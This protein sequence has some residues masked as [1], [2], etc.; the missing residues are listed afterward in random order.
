MVDGDRSITY[1]ELDTRSSR[2]ARLLIDDGA[3]PESIVAVA[4]T[5][6]VESI[7]AIWAVIKAGAA[8]LPVDP[9]Y[10]VERIRHLLTDSGAALGVTTAAYREALPS[11]CSWFVLD[12]DAFVSRVEQYSSEPVSTSDRTA[13]LRASNPAYVIYTSGSTGLPKGVVVSQAGLAD[14]CA[15]SVRALGV[16]ASSRTLHFTSPSFDVSIFDYL[17][18]IGSSATMVIVPLDNYGGDE[19][20][21]LL[22]RERVTHG[23]STPAALTSIDGEGLPDL[24][25]LV[26]GGEAFGADL[27]ARWAPG[28]SLLNGYGPTEAT[29]FATMSTPLAVGERV[30]L[31]DPVEGMRAYVLDTRLS[32]VPPGVVGELYLAGGGVARGYHGRQALTSDR[33]VA[34]PRDTA[35]GRMYRTG[36]MVR[37]DASG[38]LEYLGRND[39]QV[40]IRGFRIEL[41]EIDAVLGARA[42]VEFALTMGI[43]TGAGGTALVSYA[44]PAKGCAVES[45]ELLDWMR[46]SLPKHMVPSALIVIDH[47][48][49]TGAGKVD[50][51]A[52]PAPVFESRDYREP[53]TPTE[54]AVAAVFAELLGQE[55][56]GA[57]DDFFE[58]GG[59]SLIGTQVAARVGARLHK[60]VPARLLFDAP[61]VSALAAAIDTQTDQGPRLDLVARERPARIPLSLAQQR[62]WFL[63]RFDPTS[64]A[65]NIPVAVHLSGVLDADALAAAVT[66]VVERHETLRTIYPSD[67]NGPHQVIL[68]AR[69]ASVGIDR[70]RTTERDV[71]SDVLTSLGAAFD[72]ETDVP[73]RISLFEL[74]DTE[75]VLVVVVHHIAADGSSVVPLTRDVMIAY[76]ARA[77]RETPQWAPLGVQY[78]DY[79]LW[80]REMLGDVED[81]TS[82]AYAQTEFWKSALAGL[83]DQLDLP[84]DR[85][86]PPVQSLAGGE[87]P[88]EL[89]AE[90]HQALTEIARVSNASLFM[91]M[92]A[93]WAVTLSRL[94]QRGDIAV[95]SPIAGRGEAQLDDLI[96]MFAN[97]IV[98]RT[99]VRWDETFAD[100]LRSVR[101]T[102]LEA[103]A[104]ADVPF[105]TLV[106]ALDTVRSTARHPLFQVGLSFQNIARTELVLPELT[107]T[108]VEADASVSKFDLHLIV[109]D[110]YSAQGD[111]SGLQVVLTYASAL[112]DRSTAAATLDRYVRVLRAIVADPRIAIGDI[113]LLDAPE[114]VVA[115]DTRNATAR[116]VDE[117]STLVSLFDAAVDK[118][119]DATAVVFRSER[120]TYARFD[121]R[122]NALARHLVSLRIGPESLVALA[123]PRSVELLVAMYA[124]VKAGAAYVPVDPAQP[125]SRTDHILQTADV[126]AV[127]TSSDVGFTT[128]ARVQ[129]VELDALD[130]GSYASSPITDSERVSTLRPSNTAYVIFTSGST[131]KPK[132]VAVSHAS[133]VNQLEW[134]RHEYRLGASDA[135]VL[136]TPVT[137][138]LSVWELWS[139]P[140]VGGRLVVAEP[141]RHREP[142]YLNEL[143][144]AEVVTT[145][146]V[147]PSM[148]ASLVSSGA[149]GLPASVERALVIGEAFPPRA[150][151]AVLRGH[152]LRVD[153]L[154]GPTEA[155]VSV[156]S[157]TVA[158]EVGE[159]D[160]IP[161]GLPEWNTQVYV[162]DARLAPV[163]DGVVGELY[164]AGVQLAR[165]YQGR[166]DLTAERFV[167]NPYS[168][169]ASRL[170]RTGD[171]VRWTTAGVLDYVGRADHQVKVRGFRIELGDIE[172]ALGS[173][174]GV[175][176]AVVVDHV[177]RHVGTTL[178]GYVV[179][180]VEPLIV[181]KALAQSLPSY[182]VPS[183]IVVLD[184]LPLTVNGKIDRSA[185]PAP[186]FETTTYRAPTTPVE[187]TVAAVVAE[188]LGAARVGADD[189]FFALGGNSLLATQVVARLGAALD[190]QV[191]VRAIFEDPTVAALA[192]RVEEHAGSGAAIPLVPVERPDVIPL[193]L[194]QRRMWFLN[195][196]DPQSATENIPVAVRLSG[197]LDL[198][199][200]AAAVR[201][202]IARHEVL[203]TMY[204][205]IDGVGTQVVLGAD[206]VDLDLVPRSVPEDALVPEVTAVVGAPFDV[207]SW[208]PLRTRVLRVAENEHV[209]VLVTHH[210][211]ADGFSMTPLARDVMI[212]YATRAEGNEPTWAPLPVQY[213]DYT[214]WQHRVLGEPDDP[215][216]TGAQ[217]EH[218]WRAELAGLPEQLELPT[219][220]PRPRAASGL[221]KSVTVD[222]GGELHARIAELARTHRAT[223]FMVVHAALAVLLSRMSGSA[224]VAVGTPMAGR[225][226]AA[227][228][229]LVGMFVNTLVLRTPIDGTASFEDVLADVARI[230]LAAFGH[231]DLPFE[232]VVEVVDP[233]RSQGRHPLVQV[234]LAFQNTERTTFELPGLTVSAVDIGTT[235][236]KMDLQVTVV[237]HW[238]GDGRPSGYGITFTYATD[239]F[240]DASVAELA[241]ALVRT[242]EAATH[243]PRG[244]VG[245]IDLLSAE[246]RRRMSTSWNDTAHVLESGATV[247]DAFDARV[248]ERPDAIAVV[249]EGSSLS[250][251]EFDAR[252]NRLARYLISVGAG[253]ERAVA[254]A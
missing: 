163:P 230:D 254:V 235:T 244:P 141:E 69:D 32:P 135:A 52:L 238:D 112:F 18:A 193:S 199:A 130:L 120:W 160:S 87:I 44:L 247:L 174:S 119:P 28:R 253:P 76:S 13:T 59:N 31:G 63:N 34:D 251:A 54:E 38:A 45:A 92:H 139:M 167:A 73:V 116:P 110:S 121:A 172:A 156:T 70:R 192:A 47:V 74:T 30:A 80:Q 21:E 134:L 220:R 12:D 11:S 162:L 4:V 237:E 98:F 176:D 68:S 118:A 127:L 196:L 33:F 182:M 94:S 102:D 42:D 232:R 189:D 197:T 234:L 231:A 178:V 175:N 155:A 210:I 56:V 101:D 15:H 105:E 35:G 137:F 19:L 195:R 149:A 190:T 60:R 62:M 104:H 23:F 145:L 187:E 117:K 191:P 61:S 241:A 115:L 10:P 200:L 225:G 205:E 242:L 233:P 113:D 57:D 24:Q 86:R 85:P 246:S 25:A 250:F 151:A 170:Y 100:F 249:F 97:T 66:D 212:A 7:T 144:A 6:S 207:Q 165:G 209:L 72:V 109:S 84:F 239:L 20:K 184:A 214:L 140:T 29:I 78:A 40:K 228:D 22:K 152:E 55:T 50:R 27:V 206:E 36:D 240:D 43:D 159:G 188:V 181:K 26:V 131:G 96:G 3:G 79:T 142:E 208:V 164:L 39:F 93:A 95:G 150:A 37:R 65:Y 146:H 168:G 180:A 122:V 108:G 229:D 204:P 64:S 107:V 218:F 126:A 91:I 133:V 223:P 185:L 166:S 51:A 129:V 201:D 67:A 48:P 114:R 202:V 1:A 138:D 169:T 236:A 89:D 198:D 53:S 8:F 226:D 106:D 16:T 14:L 143:M 245:D 77:Q 154:Y 99:H 213:A 173:V 215:E 90:L 171:L 183:V 158:R 128:D 124:V 132:G 217:Q 157:H 5:R 224:D 153:N 88:L 17:I 123:F 222:A 216:S 46:Q 81:T 71:T 227:L 203:R 41:G 75:H 221:G 2:L 103:F 243:N 125:A 147:V 49:L 194:A 179:G 186:V 9:S 248:V 111:P 252:V 148:L 83:P 82:T 136:K 161:I 219:D 211:A 177:D 58:L